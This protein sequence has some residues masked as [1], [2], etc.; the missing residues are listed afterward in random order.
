MSIL[1][2]IATRL[3]LPSI[4]V[5]TWFIEI[6]GKKLALEAKT[7]IENPEHLI[8]LKQHLRDWLVTEVKSRGLNAEWLGDLEEV[9]DA[10]LGMAPAKNVKV[11]SNGD[12]VQAVP[13]GPIVEADAVVKAATAETLAA[14]TPAETPKS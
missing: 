14:V 3:A 11:I 4:P 2:T 9:L 1:A 7:Y 8:G 6:I 12:D 13:A 10:L 5:P